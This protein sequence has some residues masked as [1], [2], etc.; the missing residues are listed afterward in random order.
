M[1]DLSQLLTQQF[2]QEMCEIFLEETKRPIILANKEG[3][4]FAATA[5]E[6]I[7][8]FHSIAKKVM[9]GEIA[10]GLVTI[11]QEQT[12]SGVK[13]G[14]N[15]PII[16]Q[17]QRI[18][19]L[20]I[21]G[22]PDIVRP[23]VGLAARTIT[24]WLKNQEQLK[25]L[26]SAVEKVG[27][28]IEEIVASTQELKASSEQIAATSEMTQQITTESISKIKNVKV[29]LDMVKDISAQTNLIGLNASIEAARAGEHGRGFAVVANEVRKLAVS[30]KDSAEKVDS[31]TGEIED[32]FTKISEK[33]NESNRINRQQSHSMNIITEMVT[34]IENEMN[35]LIDHIK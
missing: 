25:Y 26:T 35:S 8:T 33:T 12:I 22:D 31:I 23:Y 13:A 24:L 9:D 18:A 16:Y 34:A 3:I 11:E 30:S 15:L 2:A 14:I 17:G 21:S 10:E 4:I 6:R 20:G 19:N 28:K 29:I 32:I 5:K 1:E 27:E 7:G